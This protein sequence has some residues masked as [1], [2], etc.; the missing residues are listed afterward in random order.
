[1][2]AVLLVAWA[3]Q[4]DTWYPPKRF[5][6]HSANGRWRLVITPAGRQD[7]RPRGSLYRKGRL[8][9]WRQVAQWPLVN[10]MSPLSSM[11]ANDGT[12]VTF[13][14]AGGMEGD[15]VV[16]I[17]RPDGTLVRTL[18]LLDLMEKEDLA[19][20]PH[21]TSSIWW[22]GKHHLDED[23]RQLVLQVDAGNRIVEL[24]VNLDTGE[25]LVPKRALFGRPQV[26]W[27]G[28]V[29]GTDDDIA[30]LATKSCAPDYPRIARMVR[31]TGDVILEF[32]IDAD[33]RAG[34]IAVL[35]PGL[36]GLT[37]AACDALSRWSF[38]PLRRD[39]QAVP[40]LAQV[41]FSFSTTQP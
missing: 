36:F 11:V 40:A 16:E 7:D 20:L 35:K 17:Y 21:S 13:N 22:S 12:A 31:V 5:A 41:K 19:E 38:Q 37:E 24:P 15:G 27:T 32:A 4:G 6:S 28:R 2:L 29:V 26:T 8:G 10:S 39:G 14:R 1:M 23:R 30:T 25:M 33:G 18:G 3:A 9:S 34:E